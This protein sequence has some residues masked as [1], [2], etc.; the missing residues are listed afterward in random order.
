MGGSDVILSPGDDGSVLPDLRIMFFS[1]EYRDVVVR[2]LVL[3]A[4]VTAAL[5]AAPAVDG[6]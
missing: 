1:L 2:R 3:M 4:D 6:S 5:P